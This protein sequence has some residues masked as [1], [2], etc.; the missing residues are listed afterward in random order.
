[1]RLVDQ[2]LKLSFSFF[3]ILYVETESFFETRA[4]ETKWQPSEFKIYFVF[5]IA[6]EQNFVSTPI[7]RPSFFIQDFH[8]WSGRKPS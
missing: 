4:A 8:E 1:M 6:T 2:L 7:R 3:V 5:Q